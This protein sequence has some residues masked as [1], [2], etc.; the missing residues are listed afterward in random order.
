ML[1]CGADSL[2]ADRIGC[3][4][5]SLDGHAE[6]VAFMK[7]FKIPILVTGGGGYTKSNVARC[8]ANETAVLLEKSLPKEIP[9]HDYYYEYYSDAD[10]QLRIHSTSH[11]ENLNTRTYLDSMK[12]QVSRN[13]SSLESAPSVEFKEA[14]PESQLPELDDDQLNPDLRYGGTDFALLSTSTNDCLYDSD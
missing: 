9:F 11:I 5:L 8:W 6:C 7:S 4:N 14:P 10:Y 3:F 12:H 13:L 2:A 1:Q